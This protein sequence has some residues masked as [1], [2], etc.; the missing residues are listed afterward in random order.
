MRI[1]LKNILCCA[2]FFL[3]VANLCKGQTN[4]CGVK[5]IIN[6]GG[7]SVLSAPTAV[8]FTSASIN[9]TS[10][11][12]IIDHNEFLPD[13][14]INFGIP[15][16]LTEVKL[17]AYNGN[18]TDTAVSYY[19]YPGDFPT[20]T[21]NTKIYYG[22]PGVNEYLANF[23][24]LRTGGFLIAGDRTN[25]DFQNLPQ[26]GFLIKTKATGC[27]EWALNFEPSANY[28]TT[29]IDN[30]AEATDGGFFITGNT[31]GTDHFI[32]KLT[33][34]GVVTWS[35]KINIPTTFAQFAPNGLVA[36]PDGGLILTGMVW[37]ERL[38]IVR[39]DANGNIIW[40]K[41]YTYISGI[42]TSWMRNILLKEGAV[43]ISG[44]VSFSQN[45]VG[46]SNALLMKLDYA[47]GQ[48]LWTRHYSKPG[49][50]IIIGDLHSVDTAILMNSI[51]G[52]G[53]P[54]SYNITSLIKVDTAGGVINAAAITSSSEYYAAD[55]RIVPLPGKKYYVLSAGFQPLPLQ[56]YISNQTK[57]VKL[58]SAYN[59]LWSKHHA[60]VN[61]GQYFVP[62]TDAD[63]TLVMA[64]N[65]TGNLMAYYSSQSAKIV[66]RKIDSSGIEPY[67]SCMFYDQPMSKMPVQILNNP[68]HWITD[69]VTN[70]STSN[71]PLFTHNFYPEMRYKC[72]DYVDSCSFLKLSGP[73]AVCNLT[74]TY[75]YKIHKNKGCGQPTK[76]N[77]P[78]SVIVILKT[79]SEITLRFPAFGNYKI[80]GSL[81]FGCSPLLD[82][83]MVVAASST[84]PLNLG[85][86]TSLCPNNTAVL[87]AGPGFLSYQWQD[88][89]IDEVYTVTNP[90]QYW[91]R[92]SD[93]CG[94]ILNDTINIVA[95]T[96]IPISIGVDRTKCN[97]DTLHLLAPTG[98]LNY[99]W[100][101]AY[102]INAINTQE[103]VVNPAVD[104][105]YMLKAEKTPGCFA[106]DTIRID[107]RT[108][109]RVQLGPDKSFCYGDNALINAGNDF[110]Q[111]QWSN[112][113]TTQQITVHTAGDYSVIATTT[114]GC[115][116]Y[117]TLSI[118]NV[119]ANP[120]VNLDDKTN[121][122][123]GTSWILEAGN[124]SSY[125]WQ[126]GSTSS[127]YTVSSIGTYYVTVTDIHQC[128]GSDTVRIVQ[129]L[130]LPAS[131]LPADTAICNYG[132]LLIQPTGNYSKYNWSNNAS[133]SS[134][135]ISAPGIYWLRATDANNCTGVDSILVQPKE[136]LTGFY[137][138]TAFTPDGN[139]QNDYFKPFIGG[140]VKQYQF[141]I[142]DRWGNVV[143]TTKDLLTG[144]NGIYK[145]AALDA[146]VYAWKCTYQLEGGTVKNEKGTVILIR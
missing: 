131:F 38:Y 86:D 79:D 119:W 63:E 135:N 137:I 120:V 51:T 58:D 103:V 106:F 43:Y 115:K 33:A 34:A 16:G 48:T 99:E 145:G 39:L 27:M 23:K 9:A 95:A 83:I 44:S 57:V 127:S 82:S 68:F 40:Q 49:D 102:N 28:Y 123:T 30:I 10:Y 19:F 80:E 97:N 126:D 12:F 45:D 50:E 112:G 56:P 55:S 130:S 61:V 18:C 73:Q 121:L 100:S 96:T 22:R 4:A 20:D 8:Y 113:S 21:N 53:I 118:A 140:I 125:N 35:K 107:V 124:Y 47:T 7:D 146:N 71:Q 89:S 65:E 108:S 74:N 85:P 133:T 143:F 64:G 117:D 77:I 31:D 122:C 60:A 67:T 29:R 101:P 128:K 42:F 24:A 14:P 92:V 142:Y 114:Q 84:P 81:P 46:V 37:G 88:G 62:A 132:T 66:V 54:G 59:V 111:Y 72:P 139:G 25:N 109:P 26:R 116:S 70:Y 138:P 78:P 11:K 134:I 41:E 17:I 94:N 129:M 52:T 98:F 104:T 105:A 110:A 5:A 136:C 1:I 32:M 2:S 141:T 90:G 3:L 6:P 13:M 76:W 144:W 69:R 91:V 93:S 15:S 75:T 36:M 87:H